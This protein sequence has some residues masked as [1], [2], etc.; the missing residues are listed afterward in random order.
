MRMF[1]SGLAVL[2]KPV[3]PLGMAILMIAGTYVAASSTTVAAATMSSSTSG[4]WPGVGKI[5]EPGAGGAST[6]RGVSAKTIHI[7]VFNDASNTVI[8]G[9]EIELVQQAN[10]VRRLVQRGGRNQRTQG[11][12]R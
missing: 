10:R 7:A 4:V 12:D 3:L 11:R 9:L 5:C 2:R 1:C 6:V 8:P